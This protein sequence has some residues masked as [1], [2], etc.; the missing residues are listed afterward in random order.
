MSNYSIESSDYPLVF[1]AKSSE[2]GLDPLNISDNTVRIRTMTRPLTG[3]QKE[4][5]IQYGPTGNVWRVVCD[6]KES[7]DI[8]DFFLTESARAARAGTSTTF[9]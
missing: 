2:L 8:H 7:G 5:L 6:A 1:Q 4:A 9:S 3:M